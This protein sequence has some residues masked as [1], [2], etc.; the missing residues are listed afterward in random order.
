MSS[1]QLWAVTEIGT[2]DTQMTPAVG[3]ND[4]IVIFSAT[5]HN[6]SGATRVVEW[7]LVPSG[8]SPG[9]GNRI[10][11]ASIGDGVTDYSEG[12]IS[13]VVVA[14]A[15]LYAKADGTGVN[16]RGTGKIRQP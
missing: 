3:A 15:A 5:A 13:A 12:V 1:Q 14:G 9:A 10:H 16:S 7:F 6:T 11:R 8:G 2:T 4:E